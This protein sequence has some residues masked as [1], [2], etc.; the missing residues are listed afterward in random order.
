MNRR[1]PVLLAAAGAL[2]LAGCT[3]G[4]PTDEGTVSLPGASASGRS[5]GSPS[6]SATP[7]NEPL[8]LAE[9][10]APKT[11]SAAAD[12]VRGLT[13]RPDYF[14][15][16]YRRRDPYETGPATWTVL[17][18]D[19]IWRRESLAP[20]VLASLTRA[21]VRPAAGGKGP[22]YLSLTVT[23]HASVVAA[24]RDMAVSLEEPL[25]CP[26]QQLT[27][28]ERVQHMASR[29]DPFTEQRTATS[30]DNLTEFGEYVADGDGTPRR[31]DWFKHR[32]GPVTVAA[33]VRHAPGGT[34]EEKTA[35]TEQALAGVGYVTADID[36]LGRQAQGTQAPSGE[37]KGAQVPS[38]DAEGAGDE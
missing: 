5:S 23:V 21:F 30:D 35:V 24:R 14:G 36:R 15:S 6:P 27:A 10:V 12:F 29:G 32:L 22:A 11:R 16:G 8:T 20:T 1:E 7:A 31:F 26:T 17:G 28:T 34:E 4:V 33:T 37:A 13:V 18:D 25:R 3:G 9:S 2:L 38:G 19:C